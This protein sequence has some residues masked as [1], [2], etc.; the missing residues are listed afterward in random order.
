[1]R[2]IW[3]SR[4]GRPSPAERA[5]GCEAPNTERYSERRSRTYWSNQRLPLAGDGPCPPTLR[6]RR[7]RRNI[8]IRSS[9]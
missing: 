4:P 7:K 3:L 8:L 5:Y 6:D 1:M 2:E 9:E